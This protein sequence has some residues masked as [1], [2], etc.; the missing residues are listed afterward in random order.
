MNQLQDVENQQNI[1][2]PAQ[3]N[4]EKLEERIW[5][6]RP[7]VQTGAYTTIVGPPSAGVWEVDNLWWDVNGAQWKCTVD[8]DPGPAVFVQISEPVVAALGAG[9][10]DGYRAVLAA[11]GVRY[12]YD[13]AEVEWVAIS[14]GGSGGNSCVAFDRG[15]SVGSGE[16]IGGR[17]RWAVDVT[18]ESAN[19]IC[20]RAPVGDPFE[21]T[22]EVNGVLT[23]HVMQI[24]VAGTTDDI[25]LPSVAVPAGQYVRWKV[26]AG[27]A[28]PE[29]FPALLSI[30]TNLNN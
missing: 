10:P 1:G 29:N 16:Y 4:F 13:E 27:P 5:S 24:A 15:D 7:S 2:T 26:T 19:V 21:I 6:Q 9:W 23:V 18:L 3:Y 28:D 30:S 12:S 8:S 22:L 14:A 20:G 25:T 17:H 11:T